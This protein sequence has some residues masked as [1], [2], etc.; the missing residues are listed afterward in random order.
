[1]ATKKSLRN[2]ALV[3]AFVFA[4]TAAF[5]SAITPAEAKSRTYPNHTGIV[6]TTFWVGEI[7]D[8]NAAD[9]SQMMST[10]DDNWHRNYGGCDGRVVSRACKTE[11]RLSGN[12]YFPRSMKPKQNPFYLDLPYDDLNDR[13]G[14][15]N[16]GKHL[17]WAKDK[18]YKSYIKDDRVSLM[19][20]RWVRITRKGKVCYGQIQ[21]AGPGQYHNA[22]YVFGKKNSRPANK[23]YNN[24]GMDVS[25]ALNGCL[26]F[27]SLNGESDKVSWRFVEAKDVPQGP[28]KKIATKTK[29][30][31]AR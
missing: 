1:M 29:W 19:K 3:T 16:R 2:F 20:D 30:P 15:R 8:A 31:K 26:R 9:G 4:C 14:F 10:Y 5:T 12:G 23:R 7:F 18:A 11:K 27:S 22:K 28:W 17:P 24:A 25:P 13:T 21:D 6:A